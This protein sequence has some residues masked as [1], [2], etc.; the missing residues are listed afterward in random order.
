MFVDHAAFQRAMW[1]RPRRT[2]TLV[3]DLWGHDPFGAA[4]LL[5]RSRAEVRAVSGGLVCWLAAANQADAAA[6]VMALGCEG[7]TKVDVSS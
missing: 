3:H 5:V 6:A 4:L 2:D 1:Q 7:C